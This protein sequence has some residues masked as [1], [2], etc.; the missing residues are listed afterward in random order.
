MRE[1]G[2]NDL[3]GLLD[4]LQRAADDNGAK[5]SVGEILEA[6]GKRSFGP[7]LL[8]GGLLGMTP[9][10]AVPSA[11]TIIAVLTLL[12]SVQLLLGRETIWIPRVLEKLSV[13]A[14]RVRT[15]V[16][17]SRKPARVVDRLVR[18]RLLT[19]TRP[20]TDRIVAG[21]CALIALCVPPLEFL[22]FV[23]FVPSLA[24]AAIG[25]GLLA[26]DGL[27]VLIALAVSSGALG[28]LAWNLLL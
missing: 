2:P 8:L 10:A 11:P 12:V 9:V 1:N 16:K 6:I 5:L 27:L 25:L 18:P 13:K 24:I 17:I 14:D 22:P 26:R 7:L 23:A 15:A 21:V 20:I 4:E 28:L 19:L 3:T